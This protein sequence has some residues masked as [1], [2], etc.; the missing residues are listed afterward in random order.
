MLVGLDL[1]V[2]TIPPCIHASFPD[3][4]ARLGHGERE[5]PAPA[6]QGDSPDLLEV[7]EDLIRFG[8]QCKVAE[9]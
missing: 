5:N 1:V 2:E 8:S 7:V 6:S 9:S 4:G 3:L